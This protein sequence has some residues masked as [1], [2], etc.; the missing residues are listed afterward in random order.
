MHIFETVAVI[1]C[2]PKLMPIAVPRYIFDFASSE[3]EEISMLLLIWDFS[4]FLGRI[5]YKRQARH[6]MLDIT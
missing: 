2:P 4:E 5:R 3:H 6:F 1:S